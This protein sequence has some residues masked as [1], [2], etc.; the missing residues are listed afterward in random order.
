[1][2]RRD[3]WLAHD[4]RHWWVRGRLGGDGGREVNY[5]FDQEWAARAMVDQMRKA[6]VGS[7]RILT[8]L[9]GRESERRHSD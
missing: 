5:Q 9:L 7:W 6:S 8:K 2:G 4:G 3:I 1:M